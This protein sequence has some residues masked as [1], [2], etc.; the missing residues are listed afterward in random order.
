MPSPKRVV[1]LVVAL[2]LLAACAGR[3]P[4]PV[5]K[6]APA[7]TQ[8]ITA[9]TG[10]PAAGP[11]ASQNPQVQDDVAFA[12]S[13]RSGGTAGGAQL[14]DVGIA[15]QSGF[16]RITFQFAPLVG[17]SLPGVSAYKLTAQQSAA[18]SRAPT[19]LPLRL[20][21]SAGLAIVFQGTSVFDTTVSPGQP[22]LPRRPGHPSRVPMLREAAQTGDF[23]RVLS[24]AV[25][26][27]SPGYLRLLTALANPVRLAI[28]VR[29]APSTARASVAG[30]TNVAERI[31]HQVAGC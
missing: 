29:A 7:A 25:G 11:G 22:D 24:W 17:G 30:L 3:S 16:D 28:D 13:D 26:L 12:C 20:D 1:L 19:A 8:S 2:G 9:T 21:G 18:F 31:Y 23:E 10:E 15:H 6:S 5:S 4:G 14:T 27:S